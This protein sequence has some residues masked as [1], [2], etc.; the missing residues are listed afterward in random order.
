MY[1]VVGVVNHGGL[2]LALVAGVVNHWTFPGAAAGSSLTG[3]VRDLRSL[4]LAVHFLI[5]DGQEVQKVIRVVDFILTNRQPP[6]G[7]DSPVVRFD[8]VRVSDVLWFVV[9]P[10]VRFHCVF[11]RNLCRRI[12]VPA[13]TQNLITNP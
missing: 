5:P 11:I 8:S 3:G 2:P 9:Q 7:C 6:T 1:L 13:Q 12:L 4:P 10:A